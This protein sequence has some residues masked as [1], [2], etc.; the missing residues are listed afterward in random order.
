MYTGNQPSLTVK[1]LTSDNEIFGWRSKPEKTT[2]KYHWTC[3]PD[4]RCAG[5]INIR[6]T[7]FVILDRK[8]YHPDPMTVYKSL[9][10][11]SW[12]YLPEHELLIPRH[13]SP[14]RSMLDS[15]SNIWFCEAENW[16]RCVPTIWLISN[17]VFGNAI[18]NPQND[19]EWGRA[20]IMGVI[21]Q[22]IQCRTWVNVFGVG[23]QGVGGTKDFE[24]FLQYLQSKK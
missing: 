21:I 15:F 8:A 18:F 20:L 2:K 22:M 23:A 1:A 3:Q 6:K 14:V 9:G 5:Q 4:D 19:E 13:T 12:H 24:K 11:L 17:H 7:Y 16:H 10:I